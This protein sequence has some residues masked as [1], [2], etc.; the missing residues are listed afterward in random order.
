MLKKTNTFR[1]SP[2]LVKFMFRFSPKSSLLVLP[3][4]NVT[5]PEYPLKVYYDYDSFKLYLNDTGI[6][7]TSKYYKR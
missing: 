4:Y 1:F 6:L 5:I 3:C 7:C 2:K